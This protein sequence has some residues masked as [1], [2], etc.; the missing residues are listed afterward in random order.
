MFTLQLCL[1]V[2]WLFKKEVRN[3]IANLIGNLSCRNSLFIGDGH[4][5]Y[6]SKVLIQWGEIISEKVLQTSVW[7]S[8]G[9]DFAVHPFHQRSD[10]LQ[11]NT[12]GYWVTGMKDSWTKRLMFPSIIFFYNFLHNSL[13]KSFQFTFL[14][15]MTLQKIK[16][17][18]FECPKSI[19]NW[20]TK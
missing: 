12:L 1:F 6:K 19:R 9:K 14:F 18:S 17:K 2:Q 8:L 20:E 10:N 7:S 5:V 11:Y 4:P 3:W 15:F 16:I 13:R